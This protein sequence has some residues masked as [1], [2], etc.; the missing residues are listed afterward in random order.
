MKN[1]HKGEIDILFPGVATLRQRH[2]LYLILKGFPYFPLFSFSCFVN[3]E[4]RLICISQ[5]V[6]VYLLAPSNS[7]LPFFRKCEC[8]DAKRLECGLG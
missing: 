4:L 7:D 1:I 5:T 8:G 2:I 6:N 3:R